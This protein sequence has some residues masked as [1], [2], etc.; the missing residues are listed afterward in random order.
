[1]CAWTTASDSMLN[2]LARYLFLI[3]A[4]ALSCGAGASP[5]LL[6]ARHGEVQAWPAVKVMSDI[7]GSLTPEQ[8]L[9]AVEHYTTPNGAYATLGV[10]KEV[11]WLRIP[12]SVSASAERE[13][14][15]GIDYAVLNRVDVYVAEDGYIKS[16]QIIGNLQP[17]RNG[18]TRPRVPAALLHL[19]P[20]GT[21]EVLLRVENIGAMI[22]P[23]TLSE[24]GVFHGAA[25]NEQMLQGV[26]TGLSL[27]LLLYGLSQW[28][29]LREPLF[30][31]FALLVAG[32]TL[33]SIE[34]FGLGNQYLWKNN[35]WM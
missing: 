27:C 6:D 35:V 24:P 25:L 19:T 22:L 3:A 31:K 32:T 12:V 14:I 15:L 9:A 21:Q 8:A 13:W 23:I 5:L 33:F 20:G 29:S 4:L 18:V 11:V 10:H 28:V 30:G 16:H 7:D 2:L 17:E 26:L 34:F 1:M